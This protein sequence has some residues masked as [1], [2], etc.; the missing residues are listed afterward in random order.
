MHY[1]IIGYGNDLRGDDAAGRVA[2]DTIAALHLPDVTV[3]SVHQLTPELAPILAQAH[4]A[5]FL[6]ADVSGCQVVRVTHVLPRTDG[7]Y[8]GHVATPRALL[9]LARAVYGRSPDSWLI[10][11][12]AIDFTLGAPLSPQAHDGVVQAVNIVHHLLASADRSS[13]AEP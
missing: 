12:P 4:E 1:L 3:L 5:V 2:A 7:Q 11:I 8:A 9:A 13:A 6:D 10:S